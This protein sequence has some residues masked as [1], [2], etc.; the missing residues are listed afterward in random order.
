MNGYAHLPAHIAETPEA[1]ADQLVELADIN[2]TQRILEPEAGRGAILRAMNRA[3]R[4]F[5]NSPSIYYCEMNTECVR[6]LQKNHSSMLIERDFMRLPEGFKYDR[7]IM[8]PPHKNAADV[9]HIRKA[10]RHLVRGGRLAALIY[11]HWLTG[12]EKEYADFRLWLSRLRNLAG[13][14]PG[15]FPVDEAH[16]APAKVDA[17]ILTL[18]RHP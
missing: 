7:I 8:N 9:L 3:L 18:D 14:K 5:K 4:H 1:V 12:D 16:F 13:V 15:M 17:M 6:Y 11:T 2:P 10:Y